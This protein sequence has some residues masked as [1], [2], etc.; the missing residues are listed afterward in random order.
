[1][2]IVERIVFVESQL[3]EES[4]Y[5]AAAG[6]VLSCFRDWGEWAKGAIEDDFF[7]CFCGWSRAMAGGVAGQIEA[8]DLE[9][10]EQETC[11][12][13]VDVVGGDALEDLAD[14][15]LD[16][17]AVFGQRQVEG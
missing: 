12:A 14:R 1:L 9:A 8:G 10:V 4:G 16:G 11:P 13:R 2:W 15:G 3:V 7:D 17:G 5:G 6:C